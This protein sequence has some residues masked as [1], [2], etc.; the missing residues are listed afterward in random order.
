[1]GTALATLAEFKIYKR[2]PIASTNEDE[3]ITQLLDSSSSYIKEY[4][5][6]TFIDNYDEEIVKYINGSSDDTI[7]LDE[8]P[9]NG[10]VFE[11]SSDGGATYTTATEYD[12]YFITE[13]SITSGIP[14]VALYNP[15]ISVNAIRLTYTGG[16]EEI[17]SDLIQACMDLTEYFRKKEYNV[18]SS[19]AGNSVDRQDTQS[20]NRLP[21]HILRVLDNYRSIL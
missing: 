9:V 11:Y 8:Y 21:M 15:T 16:Y 14:G 6:R 17:P 2:I 10:L 5:S 12:D 20:N 7:Y 13:E 1:M 4:C 18:S 3:S 19:F